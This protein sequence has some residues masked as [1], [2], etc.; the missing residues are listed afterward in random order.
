MK[1]S[2][3]GSVGRSSLA[4]QQGG[5]LLVMRNLDGDRALRGAVLLSMG[6]L[7]SK[8][9][10]RCCSLA[11]KAVSRKGRSRPGCRLGVA[12][13][14]NKEDGLNWN[15]DARPRGLATQCNDLYLVQESKHSFL[16]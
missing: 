5:L 10:S 12:V 7:D 3:E 15:T 11:H 9:C 2:V 13:T 8:M 1:A 14:L 6:C 4:S 16:I